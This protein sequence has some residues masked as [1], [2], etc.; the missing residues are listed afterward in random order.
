MT[1]I[2]KGLGTLHTPIYAVHGKARKTLIG[3]R[4]SIRSLIRSH[5]H[6]TSVN[7]DMYSFYGPKDRIMSKEEEQKDVARLQLQMDELNAQLAELYKEPSH[8]QEEKE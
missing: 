2:I 1:Q 3:K 7:N 8:E 5:S 6:I 4:N